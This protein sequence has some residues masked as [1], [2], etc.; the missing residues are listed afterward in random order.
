MTF[1][2]FLDEA[3]KCARDASPELGVT[4][5]VSVSRCIEKDGSVSNKATW[6]VWA[7]RPSSS[8]TFIGMWVC[9]AKGPTPEIALDEFRKVLPASVPAKQSDIDSVDIESCNISPGDAADA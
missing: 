2:E 3:W 7:D 4:A 1:S 5:R 8:P 6:Y 9:D